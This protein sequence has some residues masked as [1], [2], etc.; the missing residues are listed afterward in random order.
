MAHRRRPR[1]PGTQAG[2]SQFLLRRAVRPD[3][4]R[5]HDRRHEQPAY[6]AT[7]LWRSGDGGANWRLVQQYTFCQ[8]VV[9]DQ[10]DPRRIYLSGDCA[11]WGQSGAM[12][13]VDG[14][15]SFRVNDAFPVQYSIWSATPDPNDSRKVFYSCFGGGIRHGPRPGPA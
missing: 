2:A 5:Q 4:R 8:T 9:I 13:S 14:G 3:R 10:M 1:P 6:L 7:G 11:G 15:E 12:F